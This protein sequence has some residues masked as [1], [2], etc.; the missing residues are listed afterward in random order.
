VV[1]IGNSSAAGEATSLQSQNQHLSPLHNL[2][3]EKD[4]EL[5]NI[6]LQYQELLD[7]HDLLQITMKKQSIDHH[8]EKKQLEKRFSTLLQQLHNSTNATDKLSISL[9][10]KE[11]MKNLIIQYFQRKRSKEI[12]ELIAKVLQL[13]E[14]ELVIVGLRVPANPSSYLPLNGLFST[15]IRNVVGINGQQQQQQQPIEVRYND[16]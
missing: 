3:E 7:Q 1:V 14:E 12:L 5:H 15:L 4:R 11:L 2:L 9:I 16:S 13:N 10:D 6:Q 8:T